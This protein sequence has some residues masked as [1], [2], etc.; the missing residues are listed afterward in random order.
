MN[1]PGNGRS[2]LGKRRHDGRESG[3]SIDMKDATHARE[4]RVNTPTEEEG[5]WAQGLTATAS[6]CVFVNGVIKLLHN[7]VDHRQTTFLSV[8]L[9]K[10]TDI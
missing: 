6:L 10:M 5:T 7:K 9:A 4:R 3:N 8:S 1:G 2:L